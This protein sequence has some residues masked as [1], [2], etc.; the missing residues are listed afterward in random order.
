MEQK[1]KTKVLIA[2]VG[3]LVV[4]GGALIASDS[5]ATQGRDQSKVTQVSK[6]LTG[7]YNDLDVVQANNSGVN[8]TGGNLNPNRT[9]TNNYNSNTNR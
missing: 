7:Y 3:S 6:S 8:G 9:S 5:G 4:L 1:N 2:S